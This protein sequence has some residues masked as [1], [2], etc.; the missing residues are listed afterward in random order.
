MV[1]LL[2]LSFHI[3]LLLS[4]LFCAKG[5]LEGGVKKV[6]MEAPPPFFFFS[7]FF[8]MLQIYDRDEKRQSFNCVV[9]AALLTS[10]SFLADAL[11]QFGYVIEKMVNIFGFFFIVIILLPA[12]PW[13]E[14][15]NK[16]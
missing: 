2:S 16:I 4:G 1:L 7:L 12:D 9:A 6:K 5:N 11:G 15:G 3:L 14:F 13:L 8:C 10:W